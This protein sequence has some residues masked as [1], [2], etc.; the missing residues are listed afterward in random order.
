MCGEMQKSHPLSTTLDTPPEAAVGLCGN[1]LMYL[2]ICK[3]QR[4]LR[5]GGDGE[6]ARKNFY[7]T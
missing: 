1:N 4:E 2:P 7:L 6:A 5:E 3:G